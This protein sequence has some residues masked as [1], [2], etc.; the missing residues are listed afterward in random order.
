MT[1]RGTLATSSTNL[2][3]L[4]TAI[5]HFSDPH[6]RSLYFDLYDRD[7][8]LH[9]YPGVEP[10]FASIQAFYESFWVAFPDVRITI[11]DAF[12]NGDK[13]ACRF[14]CR[15][16][17]RGPFMGVAASGKRIEFSGITILQFRAGRCVER[18][19]QADFLTVLVQI[20]AIR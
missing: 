8:V 5:R 17:H 1:T 2:T 11:D 4:E 7:C 12:E 16:T 20:G 10:G 13:L 14:T 15:G 19:S 6:S 18:W 9:G 3:T